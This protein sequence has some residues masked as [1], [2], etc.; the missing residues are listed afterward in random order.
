MDVHDFSRCSQTF[1]KVGRFVLQFSQS[2]NHFG[3]MLAMFT[4]E[5]ARAL[6]PSR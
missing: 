3:Q 6:M 1:G 2:L 4:H 5:V